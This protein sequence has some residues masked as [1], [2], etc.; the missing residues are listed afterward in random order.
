MPTPV[1]DPALLSQLN[2]GGPKPVTDPALLSQLNGEQPQSGGFIG[3]VADFFKS[4]PGGMARGLANA[5]NPSM[6]PIG[7]EL[8]AV[9]PARAQAMETLQG[10]MHQPEG[11][12]GKFGEAIGQGLGNP[13]SYIGPGSLPL[14]VGGAVLASGGSEAAGQATEGTGYEGPARVA[15]ALAGGAAAAKML[16][17]GVPKAAVPTLAELKAAADQGYNAARASGVEL[18]PQALAQFAAKAQQDI[19]NGPKYA[20]TG[21]PNG[22]APKTLDILDQLQKPPAGAAVT[23]ANIDTLR[24]QIGNIAGETREFKPTPDAKAAMVLKRQMADYLENL[25]PGAAVAGDADAFI[26]SLKQA[27]GDY[28]AAQRLGK[29]DARVGQ[30]GDQANRQIAGSLDARIRSRVGSLLDNPKS[31]RGYNSEEVAQVQRVNDGSLVANTMRQLGRG[32]A[33]VVPLGIHAAVAGATGGAALPAQAALA[34]ALYGA[35]KGSE[36]MTVSQA[37]KLTEMLAKRSPLYQQRVQALPPYDPS[38][39]RAA[40]I[41]ALLQ[42]N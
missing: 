13:Y 20:F 24:Q 35:R 17:P 3:G 23:A 5:P 9:A 4:I 25:P 11:R 14:K 27:N 18:N 10:S 34:A 22:T 42:A 8:Q 19:T 31:L 7:D 15:G 21:G 41:R 12:A 16:G 26:R 40:L 1:T 29:V 37:N 36:A 28:A 39:S 2:G 6:V 30:A 33:G 32:G 38:A